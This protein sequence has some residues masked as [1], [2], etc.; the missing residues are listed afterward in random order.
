MGEMMR[1]DLQP[2]DR[3]IWLLLI[4][5]IDAAKNIEF[6]NVRKSTDSADRLRGAVTMENGAL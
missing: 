6:K 3:V 4:L 1:Y 5:R 2:G